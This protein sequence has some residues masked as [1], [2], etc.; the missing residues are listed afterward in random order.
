MERSSFHGWSNLHRGSKVG[1]Y[2]FTG[3]P[4][5]RDFFLLRRARPGPGPHTEASAPASVEDSGFRG[6]GGQGFRRLYPGP[7]EGRLVGAD[8]ALFLP[9]LVEPAR[10]RVSCR[11]RTRNRT[12][13]LEFKD[14]YSTRLCGGSEANSYLR[15]IDLLSSFH[16]WSNLLTNPH[17]HYG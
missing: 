5:Q 1:S 6:S 16:G 9:R 14:Y 15:M 13:L 7:G 11:N 12:R 17:L 8:V 3:I 10:M 4:I 2:L